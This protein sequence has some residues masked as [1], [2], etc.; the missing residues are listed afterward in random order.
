MFLSLAMFQV[1]APA[2]SHKIP[3][4]VP[5][6]KNSLLKK[7]RLHGPDGEQHAGV[8]VRFNLQRLVFTASNNDQEED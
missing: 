4:G 6:V 3:A 7:K 1:D 2:S 8:T 5:H